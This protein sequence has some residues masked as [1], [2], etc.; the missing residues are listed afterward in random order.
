MRIAGDLAAARTD[1]EIEVRSAVG[2]ADRIDV[3][4]LPAASPACK[5][6]DRRRG[7]LAPAEL[8]IAELDLEPPGGDIEADNVTGPDPPEGAT[9]G[10]LGR[11]VQDNGAVRGSTHPP[12]ADPDHV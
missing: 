9:R 10:S 6:R 8:V 2:L 1:E 11:H 3:Q 12:I 7:R 4:P 5:R